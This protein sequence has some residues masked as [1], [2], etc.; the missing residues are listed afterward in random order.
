MS[1][2][3]SGWHRHLH[4][5]H[6]C[7]SYNKSEY[8]KSLWDMTLYITNCFSLIY[9]IIKMFTSEKSEHFKNSNEMDGI[10]N[11]RH[12]PASVTGISEV[13]YIECHIFL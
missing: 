3:T 7:A 11:P 5:V 13:L 4:N 9:Y 2:E 12:S 6:F 10:K 1:I 8:P